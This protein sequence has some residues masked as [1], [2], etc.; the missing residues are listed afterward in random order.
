MFGLPSSTE[1]KKPL[2]KSLVY[3]KFSLSSAARTHFDKDISRMDIIAEISP[4][5]TTIA[6]GQEVSSIFVVS[7][8][9]KDASPDERNIELIARL[10]PQ[11][12]LFL[13]LHG[14]DV[15]AAAWHT[16]LI[17]SPWQSSA[18]FNIPLSGLDLDAAWRNCIISIG[19]MTIDGD[20]TLE[21]QIATDEQKRRLI[22]QIGSLEAKAWKER[23]P[24]KKLELI[25][26]L[27]GLKCQ[28]EDLQ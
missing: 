23:Q 5:T 12:V 3:R 18:A 15:M 11:H 1:L 17:H 28:L 19:G 8:Q 16:R 22:S 4:A 2:P 9:L 7:V 26:K 27:H 21:E 6:A 13:L 20:R 24:R 10:I 25:E 14:T